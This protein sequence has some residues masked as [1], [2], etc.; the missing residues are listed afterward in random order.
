MAMNAVR[1]TSD[2]PGMRSNQHQQHGLDRGASI[3]GFRQPRT[4]GPVQSH[5]ALCESGYSLGRSAGVRIARR[6]RAYPFSQLVLENQG[7]VYNLAYRIL[8]DPELA[9]SAT[10]DTFLRAFRAFRDAPE[11]PDKLWIMRIVVT[12]CQEQLGALPVQDCGPRSPSPA[13][14]REGSCAASVDH[15]PSI[16]Y[17]QALLNTL[18][19]DQRV[20]LVLSDVQGLSYREIADVTGAPADVIRSRLSQG[21]TALRNA[22]LARS[23]LS[24]GVQA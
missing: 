5:V 12:A 18:L 13:D 20:A 16:D 2:V 6:N 8:G 22:L 17:A 19:P 15:Q 24:P 4:Q 7:T 23:E 14:Y 10:E 1:K 11:R 21:R 3:W 9:D